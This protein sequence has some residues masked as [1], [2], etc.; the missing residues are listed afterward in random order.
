[1]NFDELTGRIALYG[2]IPVIAIES[3]KNAIPLADALISGGLPCA[4]I[5][6]RT[7]AAAE[8]MALIKKERPDMIL[9]AGTVLTKENLKKAKDAGAMF[10]VAPGF[11]PDMVK[12]AADMGFPFIPGIATSSELEQ[13]FALG[14]RVLKFFPAELGGGV[15]MLEALSA[16]YGHTGVSFMPT[17]GVNLGNLESYLKVSTVKFVGGTW[18]AKKD[19]IA[20]GNWDAIRKNCV[21]A[22]DTARNIKRV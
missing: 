1:M 10:G 4:E 20:A 5:T 17:G 9:G 6:F 21:Q 7:A 14:C 12:A 8:V 22:L 19:D 2:I 3:A 11:N 15:K 18:I 13:A 16:P